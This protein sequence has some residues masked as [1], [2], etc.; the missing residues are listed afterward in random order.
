MTYVREAGEGAESVS[1]A[2]AQIRVEG[3]NGLVVVQD[4]RFTVKL[5][6]RGEL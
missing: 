3:D 4:V 5:A 2:L 6:L 1:A